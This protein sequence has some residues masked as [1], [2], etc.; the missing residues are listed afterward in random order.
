MPIVMES[1]ELFARI[2]R[3]LRERGHSK[4]PPAAALTFDPCI[5]IGRCDAIANWH[6]T[7][8]NHVGHRQFLLPM[9][10]SVRT[11]CLVAF[12]VMDGK[13]AVAGPDVD[14][15]RAHTRRDG[16]PRVGAC[17]A[18]A[19]RFTALANAGISGQCET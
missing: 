9:G 5:R 19:G 18:T 15:R 8:I 11:A 13:S 16:Q 2:S 4:S 14:A 12:A 10:H 1:E 6:P 17:Q 7:Q 3:Q